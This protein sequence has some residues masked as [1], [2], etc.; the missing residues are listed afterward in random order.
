MTAHSVGQELGNIVLVLEEK[1]R[2]RVTCLE[3]ENM[4]KHMQVLKCHYGNILQIVKGK[5]TLSFTS[6]RLIACEMN[7]TMSLE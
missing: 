7:S 2:N 1:S 3:S 6:A 4:Y 5:C